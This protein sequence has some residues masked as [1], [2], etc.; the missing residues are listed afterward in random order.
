[1]RKILFVLISLGPIVEL[2][3]QDA[4][5]GTNDASKDSTAFLQI[6]GPQSRFPKD[7]LWVIFLGNKSLELKGDLKKLDTMAFR[8]DPVMI[9]SIEVLKPAAAK[10]IYGHI[11]KS[12]VIF[13]HLKPEAREQMTPEQLRQFQ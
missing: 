5:K 6:G 7:V 8:F 1:M 10:E 2:S 13:I 12:G 4:P 9:E 11:G 3:A